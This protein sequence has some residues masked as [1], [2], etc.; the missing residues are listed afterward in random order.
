MAPTLFSIYFSVLLNFAF[1][2]CENGVY[3]RTRSDGSLFNIARLRSYRRAEM[4]LCREL[5]FA[6][7]VALVAHEEHA[8]KRL[9]NK[10][11]HA[12]DVFSL[13]MCISKTEVLVQGANEDPAITLNGSQLAVV[14]KFTYLGSV[15][16]KGGFMEDEVNTRIGKAAAAFG[17]LIRRAWTNGKLTMKTKMLIYQSCVLSSL[18]YGSESWTLYS[19]QEKRLNSFHLRCLRKILSIKWQDKITNVEVSRCAGLPTVFEMLK[20][21]RLRWL[22]HVYRMDDDR[23]PRKI[24]YA[25][26]AEGRRPIGRP[27]L[28]YKDVYRATLKKFEVNLENWE[29]VAADRSRWRSTVQGGVERYR[30]RWTQRETQ[31]R[32]RRHAPDQQEGERQFQCTYCGRLCRANIGLISHERLCRFGGNQLGL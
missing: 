4:V 6:D 11:S 22:S 31:R 29:E 25:E 23:L 20:E 30:T 15:M 17:K 21:R 8:L 28:R 13:E 18:M 2:E 19:R 12:C 27:K 9:I 5:L 16:S 10:L 24:L 1:G 32:Q 14:D 26:L 7:D 3:L